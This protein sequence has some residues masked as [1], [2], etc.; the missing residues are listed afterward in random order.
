MKRKPLLILAAFLLLVAAIIA[1]V[2]YYSSREKEAEFTVVCEAEPEPCRLVYGLPIDSF[3][4]VEEVVKP[5][6]YLSQIFQDIGVSQDILAKC[7]TLDREA[8]DVRT[9]RAGKRHLTLYPSEPPC[10][11]SY[12]V[13]EKSLTEYVVFDF[14]DSLGITYGSKPVRIETDTVYAEIESS[15]WN[16]AVGNGLPPAF[17]MKLSDIYSWTVDFFG[18][19]KGDYFAAVYDRVY[20]DSTLVE[21]GKIHACLFSSG[22]KEIFGFAFEQDSVWSYFDQDGQSLRR[23]FLKA[24][25]NYSRISSHFSHARMHPVHRV[26]RPHTGVDYAAP[27]GTPVVSI[28]DGVVIERGYKGGGGN[29]VKIRHNSVYTTAY[30]HL[31]KFGSGIQVGSRVSQGQVIGYVG[32]TGTSTG[33]HLDFRVWMNGKPINPLSMESPPVEPI[34]EDLKHEFDSIKTIYL[35]VLSRQ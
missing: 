11:P 3:I 17:A 4:V 27:S 9:L 25:L 8:F 15:L 12:W 23:A 1:V 35:P 18:L 16:A 20:V 31:S 33:P 21:I 5:N 22:G 14:T 26:V 32:S 34:H 24:P 29:T 7:N 10:K 19:Q 2:Y 13:Y 6:T 28:G 30:L